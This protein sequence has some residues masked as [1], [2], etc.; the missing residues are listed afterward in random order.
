MRQEC[1]ARI[2]IPLERRPGNA[3]NVEI[4]QPA[5]RC[6]EKRPHHWPNS[7]TAIRWLASGGE[8]LVFGCCCPP[9][10]LDDGRGEQTPAGGGTSPPNPPCTPPSPCEMCNGV[11]FYV[12]QP[13]PQ[14]GSAGVNSG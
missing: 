2:R 13:G 10:P 6:I 12:S 3:L 9:C 1:N 8:A 7:M 5:D 11:G 14:A 4:G